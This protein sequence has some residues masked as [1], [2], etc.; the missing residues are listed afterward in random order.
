MIKLGLLYPLV[1]GAAVLE[2][3]LDLGFGQVERLGELEPPGPGD[4]LVPLVLQLES[5]RLVGREGGSL[6]TLTSVFASTSRH[7]NDNLR[8]MLRFGVTLIL[9]YFLVILESF[10][11]LK[12]AFVLST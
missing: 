10:D 5:Q 1:L 3:D 11:H 12:E 6:A 2:P 4:V 9:L 8:V 7:W